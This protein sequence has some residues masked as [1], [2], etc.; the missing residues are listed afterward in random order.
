M[1]Y[2][3]NEQLYNYFKSEIETLGQKEIDELRGEMKDLKEEEIRKIT[4]R[5]REKYQKRERYKLRELNTDHSTQINKINQ[6]NHRL[7][8]EKRQT[9][10][11]KIFDEVRKRLEAHVDTDAYMEQ[12]IEKIK[13]LYETF[14]KEN[15][16][17]YIGEH[18]TRLKKAITEHF[19]DH[20][21]IH[22]VSHITIGGY[23]AECE[24]KGLRADETLDTCL[25]D[26][27]DWFYA[28]AD[29]FIRK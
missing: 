29:L 28:N 17:F 4:T 13:A 8:M 22:A 12:M 2:V 14:G 6:K 26:N 23:V 16:V 25:R 19:P 18:D 5:L 21:G 10:L 27:R 15:V 11:E 7:L 1:D 20:D 24:A 3:T 9:L